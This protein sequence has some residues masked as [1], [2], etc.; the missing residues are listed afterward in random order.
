MYICQVGDKLYGSYSKA[1]FFEAFITG[2]TAVGNFW[3][4]GRA[5]R[6]ELQGSFRWA[7]SDDNLSFDGFF[8]RVS[9]NG[10]ESRQTEKRISGAAPTHDQCLVPYT[11]G[12]VTGAYFR[13][14]DNDDQPGR[15]D[16]CSDQYGQVYGSFDEPDGYLEGWSVRN[17]TGFHGYRYQG[18][19]KSGAYILR[20]TEEGVI[21]GWYWRGPLVKSENIVLAN[22]ESYYLAEEITSL[23]KCE[24]FGP[25]FLRRLRGGGPGDNSASS[26][27][28]SVLTFVFAVALALLF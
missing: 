8:S 6:N 2:R 19:L 18:D 20:A 22:S 4:G 15:A 24:R 1:G 10:R 25:G 21:R 11:G 16:I 14:T 26:A 12:R 28:L 7:M 5:Y 27:T 3:E 23:D 13:N 9:Q 17:G